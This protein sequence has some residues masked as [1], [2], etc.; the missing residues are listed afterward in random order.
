MP[1][2][3]FNQDFTRIYS[4]DIAPMY[5]SKFT[6]SSVTVTTFNMFKD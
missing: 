4:S 2:T 5:T 1:A 6:E 3:H